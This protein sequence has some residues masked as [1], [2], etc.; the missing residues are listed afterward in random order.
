M[1]QVKFLREPGYIYDL[2]YIHIYHF[3]RNY[4]INHHVN[5]D[6]IDDDISFYDGVMYEFSDISE[7][8]FLFFYLRDNGKCFFTTCYYGPYQENFISDYNLSFI[9][10]LLWDEK[11]IVKK[12][13]KYYFDKINWNELDFYC[14]SITEMAKLIKN[15]DYDDRVKSHLY[16]F[17]INPAQFIEKLNQSLLSVDSLLM[18]YYERNIQ[19]IID[20]QNQINID[21]LIKH[22]KNLENHK[23]NKDLFD[24][25]YI[26]ICLLHKNCIYNFLNDSN[27]VILLGYDYINRIAFLK[28]QQMP[29]ALEEIGNVLSEKNR[30]A[31]LDIILKKKEIAIRD[32]ES[33]LNLSGTNAYYHISMMLKAHMIKSRN[34]GKVVLYSLNQNYFE[35]VIKHLEKY[36]K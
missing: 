30:I 5:Y 18:K 4:C 6:T 26:S 24:D 7:D 10:S 29:I 19:T 2:L 16:S 31:I 33:E 21:N 3:N 23:R 11:S 1:K 35:T 17:F 25:V 9:Q 12:M 22:F 14:N 36:T 27:I 28:S 15:S 13:I 34:E 20:T 32:L 8:L